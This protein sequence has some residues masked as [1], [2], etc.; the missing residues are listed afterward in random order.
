[1][2][3]ALPG[4]IGDMQET[5]DAAEVDECAVVGEVLDDT[6]GHVAFLQLFKEFFAFGRVFGFD[7]RTAGYDN[8]VPLLVELNDLEFK[9]L[10]FE[11]A[12]VTNRANINKRA[13]QECP[14]IVDLNRESAFDATIITPSTTSPAS[15]AFSRSIQ[16][17]AR[18]AFSRES[19]VSPKPSSTA[20]SATSTSSPTEMPPS[21]LSF[22]NCSMGITASDL[23]PAL[24]STTSSFTAT[25]V[26]V[27]IEPGF[28][29]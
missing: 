1:M 9:A 11:V 5:V 24:T 17:R 22:L 16:V 2:F 15:N 4:H 29:C 10:A 13:W 21:C 23:R 3:D 6:L 12:W 26:P 28:I 27:M 19:L 8:V 20:S 18:I 25:T 14:D 7:N